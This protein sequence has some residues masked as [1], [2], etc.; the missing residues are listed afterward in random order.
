MASAATPSA[1]PRP[2]WF[3]RCIMLG[4]RTLLLTLLFTAAGMAVGLFCGIIGTATLAATR[5][6][7]ANMANAYWHVAI[8]TAV[9]AGS[10]T[11]LWNV[12]QSIRALASKK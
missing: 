10:C 11:F 8:P 3:V 12:V 7:H 9:V 2:G 1:K 4:F 6:E 5:G